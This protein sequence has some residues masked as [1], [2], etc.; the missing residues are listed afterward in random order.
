MFLVISVQSYRGNEAVQ[1][2]PT[3]A[4]TKTSHQRLNAS[5]LTFISHNQLLVIRRR[6]I[7]SFG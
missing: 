6:L 1:Y 4:N 2:E 3:T 7:R 5:Y